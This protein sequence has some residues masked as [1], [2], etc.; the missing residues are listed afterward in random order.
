[1]AWRL[2]FRPTWKSSSRKVKKKV[3]ICLSPKRV[4]FALAHL[5]LCHLDVTQI[6]T[7]EMLVDRASDELV[8]EG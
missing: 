3:P 6:G 5:V 7:T 8:R 1:M 4:G 2:A